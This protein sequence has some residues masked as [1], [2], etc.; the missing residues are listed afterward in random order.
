MLPTISFSSEGGVYSNILH[1]HYLPC[2]VQVNIRRAAVT[3]PLAL[4]RKVNDSEE[5]VGWCVRDGVVTLAMHVCAWGVRRGG[6]DD[7]PTDTET[8]A[9]TGTCLDDKVTH[10]MDQPSEP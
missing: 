1:L 3:D 10:S 5:I 7:L 8:L 9:V 6:D 2:L 4:H